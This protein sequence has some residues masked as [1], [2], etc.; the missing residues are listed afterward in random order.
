M[1]RAKVMQVFEQD[2]KEAIS[3]VKKDE[4]RRALREA[5]DLEVLNSI[6]HEIRIDFQLTQDDRIELLS[7]LN[8]FP[9]QR[10]DLVDLRESTDT[11]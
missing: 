11:A 9:P 4:Y 5:H 10:V 2:L 1:Q 7:E 6:E 3:S 8:A